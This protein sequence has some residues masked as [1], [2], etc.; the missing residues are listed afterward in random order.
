MVRHLF[1]VIPLKYLQRIEWVI[2]CVVEDYYNVLKIRCISQVN[3]FVKIVLKIF[4]AMAL[5]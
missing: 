3:M 2:I 5:N 4:N 1:S